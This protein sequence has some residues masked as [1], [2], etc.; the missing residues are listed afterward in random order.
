MSKKPKEVL[1]CILYMKFSLLFAC[2]LGACALVSCG[3]T[4]TSTSI[5]AVGLP[6]NSPSTVIN[7]PEGW[8]GYWYSGKAEVNTY[9]LTLDRYGEKRVGDAILVFVAEPFLPKTQVKDDGRPTKEEDVSVLKLNRIHRFTTG[10]Y[11]YSLMLSAFTPVSRDQYPHTLKTSLS[12]Q[13]WCGHSWWQL[14]LRNGKYESQHRSYFQGEADGESTLAGVLLEDE[15]PSLMRLDP[16][17]VPTGKQQVIP[18][19]MYNALFHAMPKVQSANIELITKGEESHLVL[20]YAANGR[21]LTYRFESKFP[22]KLLGWEEVMKGKELSSAT[23]KHS[24]KEA[25]WGQNSNKY[26]GMRETFGL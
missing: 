3:E 19:A 17:K 2:F 8:D 6:A 26:S 20:S 10:L 24:A 9:T 15:L 5:A 22:N 25:Y 7:R 1:A 14:N 16:K 21:T 18:G 13:D 11:D 12:A 23:L 4:N